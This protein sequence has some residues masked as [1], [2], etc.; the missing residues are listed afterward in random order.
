[1]GATDISTALNDLLF[2]PGLALDQALDRHRPR[3]PATHR[4]QLE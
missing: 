1:M 2:T 4:R 3:L